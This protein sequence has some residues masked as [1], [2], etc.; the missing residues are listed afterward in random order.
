VDVESSVVLDLF[1]VLKNGPIL[2]F[3]ILI[4]AELYGFMQAPG[5]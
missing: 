1:H 4:E 2:D 3:G 5:V